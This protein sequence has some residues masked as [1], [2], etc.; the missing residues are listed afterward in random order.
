MGPSTFGIEASLFVSS[1][2]V[3]WY[4]TVKAP[5]VFW[6]QISVPRHDVPCAHIHHHSFWDAEIVIF[7]YH[8]KHLWQ[9]LSCGIVIDVVNGCCGEQ[10]L[11][12]IGRAHYFVL[13]V[14]VTHTVANSCGYF[15]KTRS[16][17]MDNPR[18]KSVSIKSCFL[19]LA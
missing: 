12:Q 1:R 15:H 10:S 16:Y 5:T 17:E 19:N 2:D 6:L 8:A 9:L 3:H 14:I 18:S 4:M 7:L 13:L 11:T